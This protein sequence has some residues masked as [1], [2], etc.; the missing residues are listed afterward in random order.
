[1]VRS[2]MALICR[3]GVSG[4]GLREV[5]AHAA[6]PRGSLQHYFPGGKEQLVGEAL[7]L[8]GV[9]ASRTVGRLTEAGAA[10]GP[11]DVVAAMV[12]AWRRWLAE[13]DYAQGCPVLATVADAT[14]GSGALR[15][16]TADAF[17]AW[18]AG[19][20]AALRQAGVPAERSPGLAVLLISALEGAIVL[21]RSRRSLGPLDDVQRELT[22]LVDGA[23]QA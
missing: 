22:P 4:T 9:T 8:A 13:T 1:M 21:A 20:E 18:Q 16:A 23:V 6:A 19:V 2:A 17:A 7:A 12:G 3:Q 14:V 5:V 10:F 11:G 15:T